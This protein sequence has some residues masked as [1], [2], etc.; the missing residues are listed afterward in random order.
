MTST[1]RLL[2]L[3]SF[4]G[5]SA[6]TVAAPIAS[7][8]SGTFLLRGATVHVGDGTVL[9]QA[10]VLLRDGRVVSVTPGLGEAPADAEI[11]DCQ[12][13]HVAPGFIAADT[14]LGLVEIGAVRATRDEREVGDINPHVTSWAAFNPDSELLGVALA[15]GVLAAI[16]APRGG[17]VP[18]RSAVFLLSGWTRDDMV[19]EAPAA[20]HVDWPSARIDRRADAKKPVAE[21]ERERAERLAK[22][23]D[24]LARAKADR[25]ARAGGMPATERAED[26]RLHALEPFLDRSRPVMVH[27][28]EVKQIR[29]ALAWARR[30]DLRMILA[31][32][33]DAWRVKDEIAEASVPVIIGDVRS[34]PSQDHDPY[35]APFAQPGLLVKAG[36]KIAFTVLDATNV[37]NLPD[38]AAM[39]IPY[40]L[41]PQDALRAITSWPAEMYGISDR[42]GTLREGLMANVVVW[43]GAPLEITSR[44][45]RVFV[46]GEE[47][48]LED[49]HSRLYRKYRARPRPATDASVR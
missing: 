39:G 3:V 8:R 28:D 49:R 20:L 41:S 36:V 33:R 40:G 38:E 48:A 30:H 4:V 1:F 21:Q 24:L 29:E 34:L 26:L 35:D 14:T 7:P 45:E 19:I 13:K 43:S 11:I 25:A 22:L 42:V 2:L 12:G 31:G 32:A 6:V 44:V 16:V 27:A 18:G 10:S 5:A 46:R 23:D 9:A 17:L 37:R 15:N 47:I